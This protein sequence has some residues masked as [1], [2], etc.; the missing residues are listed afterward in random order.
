MPRTRRINPYDFIELVRRTNEPVRS[1]HAEQ[2][3]VLYHYTA[4]ASFVAI[5]EHREL[6]ATNFAY[7]NDPTEIQ[8]GIR[9]VTIVI[10]A[11]RTALSALGRR[12]LKNVLNRIANE[13]L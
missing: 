1:L 12:F 4:A 11:V 13:A 3:C 6:R 10:Q 5:V 9:L 2:A 7:L 8:Y